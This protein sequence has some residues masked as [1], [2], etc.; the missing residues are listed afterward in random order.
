M[1]KQFRVLQAITFSYYATQAVL[2]PLLPLYF[3]TK[4]YTS[5]QIG[6]LMS[7]GPFVAIFAQP[8]WGFLSDRFQTVKKIVWGLWA[9]MLISSIGLFSATDYTLSFLFMLL[10]YFFQVPSAPL[11]DSL[12]IKVAQ[13]T[14]KS[15]GGVRLFGSLGFT[16]IAL[17]S[18]WILQ[19][20]GGIQHLQYMYWVLWIFPPLF[21]FFLK[22]QPSKGER[23]SLKS[24]SVILQNK[25]LLWFLAMVLVLMIPHR[26]NDA[27]FGL[28]LSDLGASAAWVAIAWALASSSEAP[29]FAFLGR[30]LNRFQELALLGIV[31]VLYTIRWGMYALLD[32]P[33]VLGMLQTMHSV[34]FAVFWIVSVQYVA[35]TVPQE[36]QTTGQSMLAS[37]FLGLCGVIGG[38]AGGAIQE[39]YGGDGMYA[40]GAVLTAAAALLFFGTRAYYRR[41]DMRMPLK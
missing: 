3:Q 21:L 37:V 27:L 28:Y 9:L 10:V 12:T 31:G 7:F 19:W 4:G 39:A 35:R 17:N 33:Y 1:L 18:H 22:D 11:L 24:L 6:A 14:G 41:L 2:L 29:T 34:T 20:I 32:D 13:E 36:L 30:Y 16:A 26:M 25:R 8:L 23:I 15:Y 40:F 5:L 38:F